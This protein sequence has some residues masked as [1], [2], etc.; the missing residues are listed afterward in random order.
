MLQ[1]QNH[2]SIFGGVASRTSP[3]SARISR[4]SA[5][6]EGPNV[7]LAY[8]SY[9]RISRSSQ[10]IYYISEIDE[11]YYVVFLAIWFDSI[12]RSSRGNHEIIQKNDEPSG[13]INKSIAYV[14]LV[15]LICCIIIRRGDGIYIRFQFIFR[16]IE[17]YLFVEYIY[18]L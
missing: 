4:R 2:F 16:I 11:Y 6:N 15:I 13:K 3:T 12:S 9:F 14:H 18:Y 7:G 10:Y 17:N 1:S 8:M 5:S